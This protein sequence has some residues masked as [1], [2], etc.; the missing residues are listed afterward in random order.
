MIVYALVDPASREIRYVGQTVRSQA[1]RLSQH[2]R[3]AREKTTPPVNAWM[4]GLTDAGFKPEM[5]ELESYSSKD[6]M[7][8]GECFWITQFVG[9]GAKLLN[10]APGG[11]TRKGYR[12]SA[13]TRE[14]WSRERRGE[15]AGNYGKR[16]T[17]EQKAMFSEITKQRWRDRPHPMLGKPRSPE[18]VE[19]MRAARAGRP[20][21][22]EHRAALA[23]GLRRRWEAYRAKKG[24]Q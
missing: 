23:E 8:C 9:I 19:K 14:R 11:S 5:V 16:R 6:E 20:I 7:L 18:T 21:S 2:L 24:T 15:R 10:I 3:A 17:P 1:V 4:R 22:A 12:H 13:E